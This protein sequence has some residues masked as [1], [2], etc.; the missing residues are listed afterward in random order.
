MDLKT[1]KQEFDPLLIAFIEKKIK[2]LKNYG[3]KDLINYLSHLKRV[4]ENGKRIRP[5]LAFLNYKAYGGTKDKDAMKLFVFMEIFHTFCL[6]HDDIIDKA[7]YRHGVESM[8]TF[9]LN[10]KNSFINQVHYG[11]SIGILTGDFLFSW[12]FEILLQ[13]KEFETE[14]NKRVKQI[15]FKLI[16]EVLVGQFLDVATANRDKAD[17]DVIIQKT[18]LKTA[19]YSFIWPMIIGASLVKDPKND[20]FL[21]KFGLYLG[22][23]FQ[24][25]DDLFDMIHDDAQLKK[26]SFNDIEQH[27]HTIFTNYIF[28]KGTKSQKDILQK[29]WGKKITSKDRGLLRKIFNESG[30]I[31]YGKS[32]MRINLRKAKSLLKDT[33]LS[34]DYKEIFLDFVNL[35]ENRNS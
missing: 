33:D 32:L 3:S 19:G 21:D 10:N 16:E 28:E 5:Y 4:L 22:L 27:Q 13:N 9:A 20:R 2:L 24:L 18:T 25:Q 34:K 7:D 11:E 1:F 15:F 23:V 8:Q 35:I 26:T 14:I 6:V 31:E 17:R 29:Y 30:A 12:A